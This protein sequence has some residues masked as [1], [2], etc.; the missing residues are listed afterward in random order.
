VYIPRSIAEEILKYSLNAMPHEACG[1]LTGP[2]LAC[3]LVTNRSQ[4]EGYFEM[5]PDEQLAIWLAAAE[6]GRS[7]EMV[8]HSHPTMDARPSP[9]DIEMAFD[10][11]LIYLICAPNREGS[12]QLRAWRIV[13]GATTEIPIK[14]EEGA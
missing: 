9:A 7:V 10:Q 12:E 13:A 6:Q 4:V 8:W 11:E 5:D 1:V 2:A 14:L 3:H